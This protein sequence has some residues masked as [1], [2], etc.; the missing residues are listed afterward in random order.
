MKRIIDIPF[1]HPR[2]VSA[3]F[4]DARFAKLRNTVWNELRDEASADA[5]IRDVVTL[6]ISAADHLAAAD[7]A[8]RPSG[9]ENELRPVY[10]VSPD[11]RLP[12]PALS[13]NLTVRLAA[14]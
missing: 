6:R 13:F 9:S 2:N 12:V 8:A 7:T 3:I 10:C 5:A 14:S 4:A 1:G 11:N